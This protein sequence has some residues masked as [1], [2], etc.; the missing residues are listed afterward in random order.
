M[1]KHNTRARSAS[2]MAVVQHYAFLL[3]HVN[4]ALDYNYG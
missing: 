4:W 2:Y 1:I 3:P